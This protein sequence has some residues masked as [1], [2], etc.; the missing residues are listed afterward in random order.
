MSRR[1]L[2]RPESEAQRCDSA[3][4]DT[5][6][7]EVDAP[8]R[9]RPPAA[10]A[11]RR[12]PAYIM[13]RG[14]G[15]DPPSCSPVNDVQMVDESRLLEAATPRLNFV[16]KDVQSFQFASARGARQRNSVDIS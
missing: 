16:A 13:S 3:M 10:G 15:E 8:S 11:R 14:P 12:A 9:D 7:R 5:T 4:H 1:A 6:D 2:A